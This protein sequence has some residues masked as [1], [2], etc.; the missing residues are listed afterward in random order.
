[1]IQLQYV[2]KYLL[3]EYIDYVSTVHAPGGV[4]RKTEKTQ[5]KKAS[6]SIQKKKIET[7]LI[8][9]EPYG[10]SYDL[11]LFILLYYRQ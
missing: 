3:R 11:Y 9:V 1:M 4:K 5:S 7:T 8:T 6:K 10:S 2:L